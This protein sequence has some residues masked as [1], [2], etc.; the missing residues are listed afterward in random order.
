MHDWPPNT[1]QAVPVIARDLAAR[2]Q[3]PGRIAYTPGTSR[4]AARSATPLPSGPDPQTR[5]AAALANA[6]LVRLFR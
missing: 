4:S 1:V 5:P 3:C 2:G 6:V